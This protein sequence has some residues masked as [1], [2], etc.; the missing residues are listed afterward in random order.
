MNGANRFEAVLGDAERHRSTVVIAAPD[1][2]RTRGADLLQQVGADELIDSLSGGFARDIRR[3]FNSAIFAPRSRG[4]QY[5]TPYRKA[6]KRR[7]LMGSFGDRS[8]PRNAII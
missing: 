1:R 2:E 5:S 7:D 4:P 6:K 3:Q 8:S